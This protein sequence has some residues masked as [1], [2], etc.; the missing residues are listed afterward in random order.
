ML[1]K[2]RNFSK[3]KLATVLVAI[4]II[5]FVFWGMGSVFQG[6]KTNSVAKI[7]NFNISTKDFVDHI[8]KSKLN[9]DIIKEN[10]NNNILEEFLTELVSNSL[11]DIEIK[12]LNIMISDK[13]LAE[14]I[15]KNKSFHD[16]KN[17][18][19]R[20]KYEKFLLENNIPAAEFEIRLRKNE[21]K[22]E[23]FTYISGGIKSPYFIANKTF[24]D[25]AKKI[26]LSYI[27]LNHVYK[28]KDEF[29]NIEIDTFIKDNEEKLKIELIDF[30]YTKI[31]PLNLVQE[32]EFSE[33][34]FSNID[35]I[36]NQVLN[37]TK[38]KEIATNFGLKISEVNNFDD[39]NNND[40]LFK[41]I[42]V[43][44][45]QDKIQIIDKNDFYLL[46]EINSIKKV[47]PERN[48]VK[49]IESVK[50][51]LF[52]K[53]KYEYNKNLLLKIQNQNFDNYDFIRLV[54]NKDLIKETK[55]NSLNDN[56]LFT[57]D[58]IKL[59]YSLSKNNFLL[60]GD[61]DKNIYLAKIEKILSNDLSDKNDLSNYTIKANIQIKND[62]YSSYDYLI[63]DKYKIT[64]NQNTLERIKNYFR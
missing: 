13:N 15:R 46:Y 31:T 28:K 58:S 45:N 3:G 27:N 34:F 53:N 11:I 16:E 9:T 37:D 54:D 29:S 62:L 25:N 1:N 55:I 50:N 5:P 22:K 51:S 23:L 40:L 43:K 56:N 7:N 21:L 24:K 18:F 14:R 6:G 26:D 30:S 60:I 63:N 39:R 59:L 17:K 10:I 42:Y 32:T 4:I 44:R 41:Q 64:I 49:F 12:D 47:L 38:I 2:L 20:L 52:E 36:E 48:D 8:N 19:S 33:N 57:S 61:K 35:E